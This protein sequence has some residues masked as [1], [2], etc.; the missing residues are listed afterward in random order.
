MVTK[1]EAKQEIKTRVAAFKDNLNQYTQVNYKEAQVRKEFI[2]KFF[3][4]LGW[5]VNN[6]QGLAEQYKEVINEDSIKISGNTK[7]PDYAFRIGT[8]RVFF[9]E[10]KKP[11]INIKDDPEPALQLRRYAWNAKIPISILTSFRGFAIYDCRIKPESK[12]GASV[13]RLQYFDF[14][15]YD[16]KFD[17]IWD[18][19]SK[20]A[21]L[22]GS[23]DRYV[24]ASKDKRGGTEVDYEFLKEIEGWRELLAKNIAIRNPNLSISEMN[25]AV[26]RTIDRLLF[27]RI[28]EDRNIESYEALK[29]IS[30][31]EEVY[32]HLLAYFKNADDKYN[33]GIF[34][35]TTDVITSNIEIDDKILTKI[36]NDLYYPISPYDFAVIKIEILGSVYERFLGSTIR[37]T[38]AHKAK[39]EEK[40]EVRKAGGVYYTPE[41]VVDYIIRNTVGK[42]IAGKSPKEIE[43][44]RILDP[45]S[46]SGTFLVRAYAYLLDYHLNYF[47]KDVK[48]YKKYIYQIKENVWNLTTEIRKKILINNI[49]GVDIDPQ[50]VELAKL[51]LLLK[52]LENETKESINQ[53]LKL[54]KERALPNLDNNI[55]CGNSIVDSSYFKQ[56]R[57]NKGMEELGKVNPF[58]WSND[59]KGFGTILKE[60]GF[61]VIIGNPPYVKEYTNVGIFEDVKV[62]DLKKYYQGKMDIWYIF[63]CKA[64]DL[65]KDGGLHSFIAQNNWI[66]SAGASKLRNKVLTESVL[67][68]FFDFNDFMVFKD[69]SIQTMIFVLKKKKP[70]AKYT[71]EYNKVIDKDITKNQLENYLL[72][73]KGGG[74][75]YV[76]AEIN[77]TNLIDKT[78]SFVDSD[79]DDVLKTIS[80]NS[81]YKFRGEDIST[82]IDIH[83]D[84]VND[85]HLEILKTDDI[86]KGEGIFALRNDELN[87]LKLSQHERQIIKPYYTTEELDQYY[88]EPKNALWVIYSDMNVRKNISQYPN[89]KSH[90]ERFRKVITSDFAPYGL[91]RAREQRFFE[92]EKIISLRKTPEPHF[93]YTDFPCYVSQ[94]YFVIKPSDINL[95][96][97]TGLLNSKLIHFWLKYKGK[98]QGDQL[99]IDKAPLLGIPLHKPNGADKE[100]A[101]IQKEIVQDVDAII[102]IK[103]RIKTIKL[104]SEIDILNKQ[105]DSIKQ[106]IDELVYTLYKI[107]SGEKA[108]ID[109]ATK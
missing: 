12:D 80:D 19:F 78:I 98:K 13:A 15:D 20:E 36:I 31:K 82:G 53:Q 67:L 107:K 44:V 62:T 94:T 105:I 77:P 66:T 73:N 5:D 21:V 23:F 1:E 8:T 49:F 48:K 101:R 9:A 81:N 88:G 32:K 50:A 85:K 63:T 26:Q 65:L 79:I 38:T 84:F 75:E 2:D 58:D 103:K 96:Y 28:A 42:Y 46:G 95:K 37:L 34:D 91:H 87:K 61:D 45:A 54:F 83:Q 40:P 47:L 109:N 89:I 97:L 74:V 93:T 70:N 52:V 71:I 17:V 11:H 6:D 4:A 22:K 72:T 18:I 39:V 10:A 30:T 56:S 51:S 35:F 108:F 24:E 25:Y 43:K 16:T 60:G 55:K 86:K 90:F 68:S 76:K 7:A 33:S 3:V 59:V 69:A 100:Q 64:I 57:I 102:E 92:G 29:N 99:Q 41:F 14:E 106:N 104:V 27:L